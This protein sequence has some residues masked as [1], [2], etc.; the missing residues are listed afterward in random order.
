MPFMFKIHYPKS[1]VTIL[2]QKYPVVLIF[3]PTPEDSDLF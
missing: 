1:S 3:S 2:T